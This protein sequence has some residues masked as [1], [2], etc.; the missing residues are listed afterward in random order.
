M[1]C[2]ASAARIG[3]AE[4]QWDPGGAHFRMKRTGFL[5]PIADRHR[6]VVL[7]VM[8]DARERDIYR[9]FV[10]RQSLGITDAGQHQEL[11]RVDD[12]SRQD[13]FPLCPR[14]TYTGLGP[15]QV[16]DPNGTLAFEH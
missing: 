3:P 7:Q 1:G 13:D 11:R 6:D 8:A 16:L 9:D 14:Y 2:F 10:C 15:F 12:T 4:L 5:P